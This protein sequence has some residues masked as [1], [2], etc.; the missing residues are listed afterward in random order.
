M[1]PVVALSALIIEASTVL[2]ALLL[3][4]S[5]TIFSRSPTE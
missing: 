3:I 4:L 1:F 2:P 5:L